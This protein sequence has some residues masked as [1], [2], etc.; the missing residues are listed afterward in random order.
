[1]KITKTQLRQIIKEE[2]LKE[3]GI[4]PKQFPLKLSQVA[5]NPEDA[6]QDVTKGQQDGNPTD[7]VIKVKPNATFPVSRLKPSQTSMKISNALGMAISMILGKMPTGG[8]LGGFISSDNHIMDGHHRWVATAMVNPNAKVG[9]YAVDFPGTDLIRILNAI[10]VGKLGITQGKEGSGG[11]DQFREEPIRQQLTILAQKG[12]KFLK[13][14]DVMMAL[15]KFTGREGKSAIEAA[16]Q[17]FVKHLGAV[18]FEVPQ[19]A[20]D[21]VDMPVI[22]PAKVPDAD[23][24]TAKALAKGEVD[25]N[26]PQASFSKGNK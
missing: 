1:M 15:K 11:F 2:I 6:K 24:I 5:Q 16:V 4:D 26:K 25:W 20:P 8:N 14:G 18:K 13:P 17:K 9:G 19:G 3:T 12:S 21:R 23:K 10:T 7:D 22:D